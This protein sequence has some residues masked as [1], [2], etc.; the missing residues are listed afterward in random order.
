[1]E[2]QMEI[3]SEE[4]TPTPSGSTTPMPPGT[5]RAPKR[6]RENDYVEQL[7]SR[8]LLLSLIN[9]VRDIKSDVAEVKARTL[10]WDIQIMELK[11]QL[12]ASNIQVETQTKII[13]QQHSKIAT[14]ENL[15]EDLYAQINSNNLIF[16]GI[17]ANGPEDARKQISKI[18]YDLRGPNPNIADIHRLGNNNSKLMVK[19]SSM[20]DKKFLF[21]NAA[22]LRNYGIRIE[23]DLSPS[24]REIK[25]IL[26]RRRRELL[27]NG[28]ATTVKVNAK[29]LLVDGRDLFD[30]DKS[31]GLM[32]KRPTVNNAPPRPQ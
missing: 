23:N 4:T 29:S 26:L 30:Y 32:T 2:R 21:T 10:D 19:F 25:N 27:D 6:R 22:K 3:T 24:Q 20:K 8:D 31:T 16:S 17:K 9:D 14:L 18:F 13:E 28:V 5:P 1:M 12:K 11:N 15:T 7:S